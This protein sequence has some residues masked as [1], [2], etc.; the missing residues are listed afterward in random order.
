[1]PRI[2][3]HYEKAALAGALLIAVA[4]AYTGLQSKN[5]VEIDFE[6][7]PKGAGNDDPS[8]KDGDKVATAISSLQI[9]QQWTQG[10]VNDRPVDLFTGVQLFVNKD[11]PNEPVDLPSSADVHSTI[12]NKWWMEHRIDPGYGD[13]P[14]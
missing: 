2:S 5:N 1:M 3:D 8:V 14:Q 13:S 10:V 4:L 7:V 9:K 6:N 11:K 12:P